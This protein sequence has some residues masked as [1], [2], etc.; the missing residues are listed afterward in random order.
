MRQ[1]RWSLPL[2]ACSRRVRRL[3]PAG[4][5]N[6]GGLLIRFGLCLYEWEASPGRSAVIWHDECSDGNVDTDQMHGANVRSRDGAE[7][8]EFREIKI[9]DHEQVDHRYCRALNKAWSQEATEMGNYR[10][11]AN[12]TKKCIRRPAGWLVLFASC[13]VLSARSVFPSFP[14]FCGPQDC[15]WPR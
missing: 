11:M 4:P 8:V 9:R 1:S 3:R 7:Q 2:R 6:G 10:R 12:I 13:F 14:L 5:R 15:P